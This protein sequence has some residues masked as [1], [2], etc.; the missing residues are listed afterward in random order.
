MK[1]VVILQDLLMP[2]RLRF[3]DL[4]KERLGNEGIQLDLIYDADASL[5]NMGELCPW[6]IPIRSKR[7]GKL[8]WQ[9]VFKRCHGSHLLIV[10]QQVRYPA[11]ILLQL[12]RG[13]GSRKHAF[14]GHGKNLKAETNQAVNEWFKRALFGYIAIGFVILLVI[15][16][17]F[18][19]F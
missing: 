6:G 4:L 19:F 5:P 18:S 1:R 8:T 11:P 17:L 13:F 15:T 16:L 10:P 2:Y 3:L 9:P 14:W 7:L 12:T